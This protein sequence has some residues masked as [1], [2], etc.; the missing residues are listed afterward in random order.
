MRPWAAGAWLAGRHRAVVGGPRH[1][2]TVRSPLRSFASATGNGCRGWARRRFL[3]FPPLP[4]SPPLLSQRC[5]R[6]LTSLAP[7][8]PLPRPSAPLHTPPPLPSSPSSSSVP[9][10]SSLAS[11]AATVGLFGV[12]GL[13]APKDFEAIAR[14]AMNRSVSEDRGG[15]QPDQLPTSSLLPAIEQSL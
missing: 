8:T 5:S 14:L 3:T 4:F 15:A 1:G 7:T 11:S 9:S 12:A 2:L 10:S 6:P 13:N